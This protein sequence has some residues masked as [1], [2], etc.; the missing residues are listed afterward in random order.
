LFSAYLVSLGDAILKLD[1]SANLLAQ[2][3]KNDAREGGFQIEK[4]ALPSFFKS[5]FL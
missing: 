1:S 3:S 4:G 5:C 2:V